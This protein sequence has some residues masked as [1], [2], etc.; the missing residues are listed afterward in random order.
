MLD[1]VMAYG[2]SWKTKL[3]IDV[4]VKAHNSD[5]AQRRWEN[6]LEKIRYQTSDVSIEIPMPPN[7]QLV[8]KE[9]DADNAESS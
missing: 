1:W 8:I 7:W 5:R 3:I 2:D 6:L 9:E 4:T